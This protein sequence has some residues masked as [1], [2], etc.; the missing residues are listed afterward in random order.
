MIVF[1]KVN[2]TKTIMICHRS[3]PASACPRR[4]TTRPKPTSKDTTS[5]TLAIG[6]QML[7]CTA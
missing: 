3:M 7:V 1:A 6:M 4:D 5:T 2:T